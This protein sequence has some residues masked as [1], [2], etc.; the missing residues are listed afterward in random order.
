MKVAKLPEKLLDNA[1]Q[2]VAVGVGEMTPDD[3]NIPGNPPR[4]ITAQGMSD[5]QCDIEC[6]KSDWCGGPVDDGY[7]CGR[8]KDNMFDPTCNG[9][10]GGNCFL[11]RVK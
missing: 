1:G 9:D 8:D 11:L 7:I 10:S 2:F 3:P 6:A 5:E 4:K